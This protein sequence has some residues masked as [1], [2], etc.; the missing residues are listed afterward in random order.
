MYSHEKFKKCFT[1]VLSITSLNFALFLTKAFKFPIFW[2]GGLHL[3]LTSQQ[4]SKQ[5]THNHQISK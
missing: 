3:T 2:I 4:M 1:Y 5:L